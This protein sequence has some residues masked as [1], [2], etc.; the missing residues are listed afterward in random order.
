MARKRRGSALAAGEAAAFRAV[1]SV[2]TSP[3]VDDERGPSEDLA[4]DVGDVADGLQSA[5]TVPVDPRA[6]AFF[7]V[8]GTVLQGASLFHLARGLRARG[9]FGFRDMVHFARR[10]AA[11]RLVGVEDPE[12]MREARETALEFIRG[13]GVDELTT[14]GEEIFDDVLADKVWPGTQAYARMHLDSG[15]RVWLVTATPVE[16]ASVIAS[17]LGLTGALGTVAE[18]ENGIYTGRLVGEVL[19]GLAKAEAVR[20]LA[21]RE[22]LDLSRCSAYSDSFNDMPLLDL[23]GHPCA[24]NPDPRLRVHAK[25][26][27]WQVQDYRTGRKAARVGLAAAMT[28][29]AVAGIVA[30]GRAARRRR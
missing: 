13:R 2:A 9:F 11:F 26:H 18:S 16:V 30:G 6:A 19:H 24:I 3:T 4:A 21:D 17:R 8:D 27:G 23:V 22:G 20:A 14:I 10:Q 28:G 1:N 29:A 15:E 5:L 7:D 12:A 25:L